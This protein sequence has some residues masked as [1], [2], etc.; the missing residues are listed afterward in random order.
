[1]LTNLQ[2]ELSR[3]D[4]HSLGVLL[5]TAGMSE[6]QS[7][8]R[9]HGLLTAVATTPGM[10]MPGVWLPA[11]WG[12]QTELDDLQHAQASLNLIMRFY[13]QIIRE[14][15]LAPKTFVPIGYPD[16]DAVAAWC[17]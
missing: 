9:V 7:L 5:S 12:D 15:T 4:L 14:M 13:N 10:P 2:A 8:A 16:V 3:D 6:V 17:R 11:V 1:M